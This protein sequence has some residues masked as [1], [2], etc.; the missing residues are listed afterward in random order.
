MLKKL[1][2]RRAVRRLLGTLGDWDDLIRALPRQVGDVLRMFQRQEIGVQLSHRHLEPSVNRLVFGLMVSALFVGS[3][4]MWA[5]KAA[6]AVERGLDLRRGG[7]P[8][9]RRP[10][11]TG[12]SAIQHSGKLEDRDRAE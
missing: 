5:A 2:P 3:A 11:A 9:R 8:R 1:S 10:W 7:L 4:M 12:C 6:A